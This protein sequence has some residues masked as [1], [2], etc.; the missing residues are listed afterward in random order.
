MATSTPGTHDPNIKCFNNAS[1][2][3]VS[4][5]VN[6]SPTDKV[7]NVLHNCVGWAAGRFNQ[8]YNILSGTPNQMKYQ[9]ACNA[10]DFIERAKALGLST[11][12]EPQVGAIM[13]WQKG[14][15][16]NS[17]DGAGHVAIV[18]RVD[19]ADTVYTSESGWRDSEKLRNRT[20]HKGDGNWGSSN[21]YKFRGFIY[22]PAVTAKTGGGDVPKI[23]ATESKNKIW[24]YLR[25]KGLS[26][27][28]TAGAM[29]CWEAESSNK[30]DRVEGDYLKSY[31]GSS[32]VLASKK[33]IDNYTQ[34]KLFK[35]Y[36]NNNPPIN[37]NKDGYKGSD[38]YYYPGI[39]LAQ[40]TGP[41]AQKLIDYGTQT[42]QNF[43]DVN[44]QLNYFWS[45]FQNRTGLKDKLNSATNP[46]DA[47]TTFLDGFEMSAGWHNSC[48]TGRKQNTA[49]RANAQSIYNSYKGTDVSV[50]AVKHVPVIGSGSGLSTY[51]FTN[52]ANSMSGI[53]AGSST[54][55]VSRTSKTMPVT[56]DAN[57]ESV[58]K[59][60]TTIAKNTSYLELLKSLVEIEKDHLDVSS[61]LNSSKSSS[62][63]NAS[64]DVSKT[65]EDSIT[66]M[67]AKLDNI[68]Q[69]L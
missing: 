3:G 17:G 36:A 50:E 16:G 43:R 18:E 21:P 64:E 57:S 49:R 24:K 11:G 62:S 39:G 31:P 44:T 46:Q 52:P 59:L 38:G 54:R 33:S 34:N 6:G 28:A 20:R 63:T 19:S 22:N 26:E 69:A 27:Y 40:W 65:I 42:G 14:N 13:V 47:A 29:G 61:Q 4:S 9:L 12:Q 35:I 32:T 60:L 8:I 25:R 66:Q 67:K 2:G 53:G 68:S 37:I 51:D 45:E 5:C 23:S 15:Y 55:V 41:R 10:E 48:D 56:N 58:L 7:C 30:A 1:N